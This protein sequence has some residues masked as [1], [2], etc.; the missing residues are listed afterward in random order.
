M[1]VDEQSEESA[2]GTLHGHESHRDPLD[3]HPGKGFAGYYDDPDD[4]TQFTI[5]PLS[6]DTGGYYTNWITAEDTD[7]VINLRD[8]L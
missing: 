4:Q 3:D 7:D 5:R 2:G 6:Y 8:M 1:S